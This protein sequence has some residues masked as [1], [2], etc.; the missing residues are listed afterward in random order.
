MESRKNLKLNENLK[1][2]IK[3]GDEVGMLIIKKDGKE[4]AKTPLIAE[5]N[6]ESSVLVEV[7]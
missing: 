3:K 6:V 2:P 5:K 4:I 7:V 1:A